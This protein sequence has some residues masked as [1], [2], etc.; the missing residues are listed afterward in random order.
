[1]TVC[2]IVLNYHGT[3]KTRICLESLLS[4]EIECVFILDNSESDAEYESLCRMINEVRG[5]TNHTEIV[6]EK[7]KFNRGFAATVNHAVERIKSWG[8]PF[9]YY[10]LMNNDAKMLSGTLQKLVMFMDN[11]NVSAVTPTIIVGEEITKALW[12]N[13]LV[14]AITR[15]RTPFSFPYITGCCMLIRTGD[16]SQNNELLDDSFFMYG[17]DIFFCWTVE[18]QNGQVACLDNIFVSHAEMGSSRGKGDL[19]VEYHLA[20]ARLLIAIKAR[21]Y[22]LEIPFQVVGHCLYLLFRAVLRTFRYGHL[23][24]LIAFSLMWFPLA[25]RPKSR[26]LSNSAGNKLNRFQ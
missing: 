13:R 9:E 18:Q 10:L 4:E 14:G 1:M 21:C 2:A 3:R 15:S 20:R 11:N 16:I 6:L 23:D 19:F 26:H 12:Y 8:N 17:E 24:P 22:I 25:I 5:H 7:M